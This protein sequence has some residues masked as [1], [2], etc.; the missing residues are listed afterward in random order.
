MPI[1]ATLTTGET[2]QLEKD[3]DCLTHEGPHWLH[4]DAIARLFHEE[5]LRHAE[6]PLA[7]FVLIRVAEQEAERLK[8]KADKMKALGIVRIWQEE[9]DG[10]AVEGSEKGTGIPAKPQPG[11]GR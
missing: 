7:E 3:C 6:G 4:V 1:Y 10:T 8:C 11:L 9:T 5:T 2:V